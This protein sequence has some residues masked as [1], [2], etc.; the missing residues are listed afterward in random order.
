MT[1]DETAAADEKGL[2]AID[3]RSPEGIARRL[4]FSAE[5]GLL[6][7]AG[8]IVF[9]D[10]R[11]VGPVHR[12]FRIWIGEPRGQNHQRLRHEVSS[13]SHDPAEV[14][15]FFNQPSCPL[16]RAPAPLYKI[17][18]EQAVSV[19]ALEACAG[20]YERPGDPPV[21]YTVWRQGQHLMIKRAESITGIEIKAE[22]ELDYFIRFLN[23]EFHFV[24]DDSGKVVA[25]DF[26]PERA[27]RA[28][29]VKPT[30][31]EK[32]Q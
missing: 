7:E 22:S 10:Y 3:A 14:Q 12:P 18:T 11:P 32:K 29:R 6:L 15:A 25:V 9:E 27:R 2:I 23:Q 17:R 20:V 31:G 13:I 26:G 4:L 19:E 28:W 1:I 30:A 21:T 16:P 8:E 24:K 5:S